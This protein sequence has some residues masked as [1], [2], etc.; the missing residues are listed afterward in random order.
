MLSIPCPR[1]IRFVCRVL[2]MPVPDVMIRE[3][4]RFV[5]MQGNVILDQPFQVHAGN[6]LICLPHQS[7]LYVDVDRNDREAYFKIA[8]SLRHIWQERNEWR[9]QGCL[10]PDERTCSSL[11]SEMDADAFAQLITSGVSGTGPPATKSWSRSDCTWR[12]NT[13][14]ATS[15]N[16]CTKPSEHLRVLFRFLQPAQIQ[17]GGVR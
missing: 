9:L 12:M 15:A 6:T 1:Y 8:H 2:E 17:A 13:A 14:P 7:R 16:V 5:D 10:D 4:G 11:E 3:K